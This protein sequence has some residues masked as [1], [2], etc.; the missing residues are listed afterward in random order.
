MKRV[1]LVVVILFILGIALRIGGIGFAEQNSVYY[2]LTKVAEGQAVPVVVHGAVYIYMHLL[3]LVYWVFGNKFV[4][5]IWLQIV[6][7]MASCGFLYGA[8][9]KMAGAIP[10]VMMLGFVM[11]TPLGI[12]QTLNL[13]PEL[14]SLLVFAI[15]L[16]VCAHCVCDGKGFVSGVIAGIFLAV[17]CYLDITGIVLVIWTVMGILLKSKR[18]MRALLCM[19]SAVAGFMALMFVDAWVSSKAIGSVILAW[20]KLYAPER[21]APSFLLSNGLLKIELLVL[22]VLIAIGIVSFW[23]VRKEEYTSVWVVP[24]I[25]L[26][27]LQCF[28]MTTEEINGSILLYIFLSVWAGISAKRL[29]VRKTVETES[30]WQTGKL[31]AQ[32]EAISREDER[33]SNTEESVLEEEQPKVQFIENPLPLPKKHVKKVMDFDWNIDEESDDFDIDV[34]EN[35]DFDI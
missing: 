23:F 11:L 18:F 27:L 33:E 31:E 29:F 9:R 35:D 3:H 7:Q 13:S 25:V 16:F 20:W 22:L 21:F 24:A 32:L 5:G 6:L 34:D 19:L 12:H 8:V 1:N 2:E 4:A 26:V 30:A 10:A 15:V 14:L 28:K 17:A